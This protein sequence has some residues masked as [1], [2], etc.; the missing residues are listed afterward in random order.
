VFVMAAPH[1]FDTGISLIGPLAETLVTDRMNGE[2]A[3]AAQPQG[4]WNQL[5]DDLR[6]LRSLDAD[7]DGQGA[8]PPTATNVDRALEWVEQ[9]RRHAQAIP[10]SRAVPGVQGEIYLEWQCESLYLV[11]EIAEPARVEWTLAVPGQPNKHWV[12]EG[13]IRYFVGPAV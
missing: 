12:T 13:P 5:L 9:M 6:R 4:P 3:S 10:P 2:E 8:E 7:W 11:A 1:S